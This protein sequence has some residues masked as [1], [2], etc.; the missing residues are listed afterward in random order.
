MFSPSIFQNLYELRRFYVDPPLTY[1]EIFM[2]HPFKH[3]NFYDP[4]P[5]FFNRPPVLYD[6]SLIFITVG[7]AAP[8][9]FVCG[10]YE[11][12]SVSRKTRNMR[13]LGNYQIYGPRIVK[14]KTDVQ[15]RLDITFKIMSGPIFLKMRYVLIILGKHITIRNK[16]L[17]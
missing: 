14:S 16:I 13:N 6:R 9:P 1:V 11:P 15:T 4:A 7:A 2:T 3:L 12:E 8:L 10:E 5:I 17:F